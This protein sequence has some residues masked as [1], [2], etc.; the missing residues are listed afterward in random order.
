MQI[1]DKHKSCEVDPPLQL[2]Y[3]SSIRIRPR[4]RDIHKTMKLTE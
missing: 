4:T 1:E 2:D 3:L